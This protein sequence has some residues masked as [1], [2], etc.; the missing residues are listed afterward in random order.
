[1]LKAGELLEIGKD[2]LHLYPDHTN[3]RVKVLFLG[4][5]VPS[6]D[7]S[8]HM[9]ISN[10]GLVSKDLFTRFQDREEANLS[11]RVNLFLFTFFN[12]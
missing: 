5:Q 4:L 8:H 3:I 10:I 7:R 12:K 11:L 6:F 9:G 2:I 1:M